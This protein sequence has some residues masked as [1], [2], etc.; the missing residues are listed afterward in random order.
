MMK[1]RLIVAAALMMFA[2]QNT[3]AQTLN[4]VKTFEF[5]IKAGTNYPLDSYVGKKCFG[6]AIG[7]EARWNLRNLPL[8]LGAEL[9]VSS[10]C[11][12]Y[13]GED[14]T[15][16]IIGISFVCD[17]NINRGE[18]VSPFVGLGLGNASCEVLTGDYGTDADKVLFTPRVGVELWRHLRLTLE[19]RIVRE[20]FNNVGFTV[21][22]V[23]GGGR[24]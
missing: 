7:L 19:S 9:A 13:N 6:A 18:N 3:D 22:Y 14:L 2:L 8:D 17:Y 24:K 16:R 5:E 15:D 10:T 12:R 4:A 1:F 23:F 21:G 20:G 11:R